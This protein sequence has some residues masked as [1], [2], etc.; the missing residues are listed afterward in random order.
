MRDYMEDQK[1]LSILSQ[2]HLLLHRWLDVT[3]LEPFL[4]LLQGGWRCGDID[5]RGEVDRDRSC[6]TTDWQLSARQI[7]G[8]RRLCRGL[9]W[10]ASLPQQL[11][12]TQN[13]ACDHSCRR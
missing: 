13:L 1:S 3:F 11:C 8:A 6:G 2:Q 4:N 5:L 7:V 10:Q 12:G 9:S